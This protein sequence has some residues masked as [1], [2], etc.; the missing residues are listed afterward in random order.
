MSNS[1]IIADKSVDYEVNEVAPAVVAA[2][3]WVLAL[4]GTAMAAIAICG[5]R[6]AKSVAIDWF[7]GKA[8]FNCR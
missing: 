2:L 1:L 5:W 6:G 3:V 8:T 4:G 7:K